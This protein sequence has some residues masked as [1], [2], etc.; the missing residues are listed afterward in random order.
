MTTLDLDFVR[1]QF[2]A[3]SQPSLQ[4]WAFFE[5]AGG[6]Y[7]CGAVIERLHRY[8]QQT[9]V[10]PYSVYPASI[11]AGQAMDEAYARLAAYLNVDPDEVHFGPSTSQNTYVLAHAFRAGWQTGD[12]IVVTNQDHE[13]NSGNWRRLEKQGIVVREW[14]IDPSSGELN[15]ADLDGLLTEKTKLVAFPHCS[16]IIG[17]FNPVAEIAAKVHAAGAVVVVDGVAAAPHGFPD[18]QTLGADIYLFSLYKTFG[19]HLGLMVVRR[20]VLEGLANQ[21][22]FFN[23][24]Y[25]HKKLTPAGPDHAQIAAANGIA[26]YF[27]AVYA[28]HF[29]DE[30]A[31]TAVRGQ[32]LHELFR[33]AEQQRLAPL[34]NWLKSR[35]DVR[36]VGPSDTVNRAPTVAIVSLRRQKSASYLATQLTEHQIMVNYGDFYAVRVLEGMNI[37]LDTGVLR[38]SFVHYTSEE[39]IAQLIDALTAVL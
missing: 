10:Q 37:P 24:A 4:G 15:L 32:R 25:P 8:Y 39:E 7:A 19:P 28:H 30:A 27:D 38:M 16:N 35:D 13:A 33:H 23:D 21:G 17:R 29:K 6:S 31:V 11:L 2:P 18:I 1:S 12:E 22:H 14:R 20:P 36:I 34:L 5:N 3:F 26:D 9:K